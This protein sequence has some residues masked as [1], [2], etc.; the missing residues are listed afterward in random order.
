MLGRRLALRSVAHANSIRPTKGC[1]QQLLFLRLAVALT[2]NAVVGQGPAATMSASSSTSASAAGALYRHDGVRILHDPYAPNMLEKYGA[3]G[4]TDGEGFDPYADSVGAGIYSGTV[5]R[6]EHDGSVI[7]GKQYQNHNPRPGPVYNGGGYTPVSKA[8]ALYR[9]EVSSGVPASDTA[10]G[11]LLDAHPDLVN[12]VATGGALPLHTC[13]M[14][15]DN[16]HATGFLI[17]RG[18]DVEGVDTYGYTPLD[19]MASNNL[20]VGAKALLAAGADPQSSGAGGPMRIA[21]QAEARGVIEALTEH[22]KKRAKAQ[23]EAISVFSDVHPEIAGRYT[24][25]D[26]SAEIPTGFADVCKENGW[27]V[28]GTWGRLNGG[29]NGSW[30]AHEENAS[31]VYFNQMDKMWWIDGPD[32]LGVYKGTAPSWAPPGGSIR[33]EALDGGTHRPTLAIYRASV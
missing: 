23:V 33:W 1:P 20:D 19:R 13:G 5:Q 21:Q 10:L 3:P 14:S 6:R 8:I 29:E 15:R 9:S 28:E 4:Q 25:R 7:I 26:G 18:A 22:G 31:Y 32:G 11:R 16:Q 27:P 2:G 24:R 30:F 17:S 12:D